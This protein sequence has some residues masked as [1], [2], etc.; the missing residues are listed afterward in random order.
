VAA[1]RA[2]ATPS[3]SSRSSS[4]ARA[5]SFS[6]ARRAGAEG[7]LTVAGDLDDPRVR[8]LAAGSGALVARHVGRAT[9]R[10]WPARRARRASSRSSSRPRHAMDEAGAT[11]ALED[12]A[13]PCSKRSV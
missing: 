13:P 1:R 7:G 3:R 10:R 12:A 6:S 9:P 8:R 5:R 11:H 4:W 2:R